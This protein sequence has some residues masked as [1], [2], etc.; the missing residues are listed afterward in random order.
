MPPLQ[1][2]VKHTDRETQEELRL[3]IDVHSSDTVRN[4]KDKI[5]II[6]G[7]APEQQTLHFRR[8]RLKDHR[9]LEHYQIDRNATLILHVKHTQQSPVHGRKSHKQ[10]RRN[11]EALLDATLSR[12][13]P[14]KRDTSR[15]SSPH[16]SKH[17]KPR[18]D[19]DD[20]SS[21]GARH[22]NKHKRRSDH[23]SVIKQMLREIQ[24]SLDSLKRA[25]D[26]NRHNGDAHDSHVHHSQHRVSSPSSPSSPSSQTNGSC[27]HHD[28]SFHHLSSSAHHIHAMEAVGHCVHH[29]HDHNPC[30]KHKTKHT[31]DGR[32]NADRRHGDSERNPKETRHHVRRQR[33]RHTIDTYFTLIEK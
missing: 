16:H 4:L 1:V 26:P 8:H 23:R 9:S 19:H 21:T 28:H 33:G 7:V 27:H 3:Q 20:A 13:R 10:P 6:E 15:A 22:K 31:Q 32:S 14:H 5:A 25:P 17:S 24:H 11:L 30:Q 29:H 12:P 2:F 18:Y